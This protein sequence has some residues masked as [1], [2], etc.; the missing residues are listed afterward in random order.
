MPLYPLRLL[1]IRDRHDTVSHH[2]EFDRTAPT[3]KRHTRLTEV[4]Q[5]ELMSAGQADVKVASTDIQL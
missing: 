3:F 5:Y 4:N 2:T 1:E